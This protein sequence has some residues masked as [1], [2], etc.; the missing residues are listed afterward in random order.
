[1]EQHFDTLQFGID[2]FAE[3][4]RTIAD[5]VSYAQAIRAVVDEAILPPDW[6]RRDR[7]R[8]TPSP[9]I[10]HL[11]SGHVLAGIATRTSRIH[12]ASGVTGPAPS[13]GAC[14]SAVRHGGRAFERAGR[15]DSGPGFVHGVVSVVRLRIARL[16]HPVRQDRLPSST[17]CWMKIRS[18]LGHR[19]RVK[20]AGCGCLSRKTGI[21][22]IS[23]PG[24]GVGGSPQIGDPHRARTASG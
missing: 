6:R 22:S 19:T 5:V 1:M 2:T 13:S 8:R 16:R 9:G 10:R 23:R 17:S 4:P 21:R 20:F 18:H 14:L 24:V 11:Q 12:L 15:G 7:G 3:I